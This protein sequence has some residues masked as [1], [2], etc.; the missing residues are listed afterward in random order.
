MPPAA[1]SSCKKSLGNGGNEASELKSSIA[2]PFCNTL[3]GVMQ[4][5]E[6]PSTPQVRDP[7]VAHFFCA[8]RLGLAVGLFFN[9]S[10]GEFVPGL[11]A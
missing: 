1:R 9:N 5:K 8:G 11:S 6:D 4:T 2:G 3:G 7:F 10:Q